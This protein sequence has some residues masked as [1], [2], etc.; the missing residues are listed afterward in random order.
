VEPTSEQLHMVVEL[1][2]GICDDHHLMQPNVTS[3]VVKLKEALTSKSAFQ[4]YFLVTNFSLKPRNNSLFFEQHFRE[5]KLNKFLEISG[6]VRDS[7][8]HL[9]A[10]RKDTIC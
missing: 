5:K 9:Q 4:K 7:N 8:Q 6:V 2:A 1:S 3:P 10:H